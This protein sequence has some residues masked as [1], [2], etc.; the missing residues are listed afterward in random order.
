MKQSIT[1][2]E[3]LS[4]YRVERRGGVRR[5]EDDAKRFNLII[6]V[7]WMIVDGKRDGDAESK[8]KI[9]IILLFTYTVIDPRESVRESD[10]VLIE[11]KLM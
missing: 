7:R 5:E 8:Q 10:G 2:P 1:I 6:Y 11:T 3:P 4:V 9:Q